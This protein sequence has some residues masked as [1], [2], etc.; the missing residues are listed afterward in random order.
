MHQTLKDTHIIKEYPDILFKIFA[1][2]ALTNTYVHS[3]PQYTKDK[4]SNVKNSIKKEK[5]SKH[6]A[7][8]TSSKLVKT[9]LLI[10]F[11]K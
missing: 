6:I 11:K 5:K 8:E 2:I 1:T 4:N 7:S 3:F 9:P 10:Q